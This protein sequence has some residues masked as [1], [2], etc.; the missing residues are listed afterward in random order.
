MAT[1]NSA[2]WLLSDSPHTDK[3]PLEPDFPYNLSWPNEPSVLSS[4]R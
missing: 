1:A 2:S 4:L 3:V